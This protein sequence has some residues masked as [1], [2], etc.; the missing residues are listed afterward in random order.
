VIAN[1]RVA[2]A[3]VCIAAALPANADG[4]DAGATDRVALNVP[5]DALITGLG[6]VGA[7]VPLIF[8]GSLAR[9]TCRWC[10]GPIGTPVNAVDDWFRQHHLLY[11]FASIASANLGSE[12][13]QIV[14]IGN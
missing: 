1:M 3:I 6:I 13:Q 9:D 2:A 10:E 4:L 7:T 11:L 12:R 14:L 5:V 8:S